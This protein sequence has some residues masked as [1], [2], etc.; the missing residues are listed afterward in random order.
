MDG[1]IDV[2]EVDGKIVG[3]GSRTD[4]H[5]TRVYVLPEYEGKGFFRHAYLK[6]K[7]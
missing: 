7:L 3:T 1:R 2:L 6:I 4:N 5:I